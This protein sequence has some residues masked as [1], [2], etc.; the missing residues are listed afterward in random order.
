MAFLDNSGDIILDAVLTDVGRKKM[1]NGTFSIVKFALGDD[2][3]DYG[4][5]NANHPSGSAYADLEILQTPVFEAFTGTNANINYGLMTFSNNS[6]LY[7]PSLVM[8]ESTVSAVASSIVYKK[9]GTVYLAMDAT[10]TAASTET[11]LTSDL[12]DAKYFLSN[13]TTTGRAILLECGLDTPQ[14]SATSTN[15]NTYLTNYNMLDTSYVVYYDTR[16]IGG[17]LGPTSATSF[18][19]DTS[20]GNV[21]FSKTL[22]SIA[23]TT[24]TDFLDNYGK[25]TV[26]G[27]TDAVYAYTGDPQDTS[28]SAIQGPRG[29]F[30]TLNF[31]IADGLNDTGF[32]LYGSL[33]DTSRFGSANQY[34]FVSTTVYIQGTT[35]GVTEQIDITIAQYS[36]T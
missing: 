17:V 2:E 5:Y 1:A 28:V 6:I 22:Q 34:N 18:S 31:T 23:G 33:N 26:S 3:I 21:T 4:L 20:T 9:N 14:L 32:S 7:M 12:G 30:T 27:M 19:N 8:N 36:G 11:K 10:T 13:N 35:S 25:A 29:T 24:A 16:F 15:R